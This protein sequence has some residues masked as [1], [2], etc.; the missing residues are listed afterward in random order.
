[1][2]PELSQVISAIVL[3]AG[4]FSGWRFAQ[5]LVGRWFDERKMAAGDDATIRQEQAKRIAELEKWL[6]DIQSEL[7][8]TEVRA[9]QA[10]AR[11]AEL[12]R[13]IKDMEQWCGQRREM[14]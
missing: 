2:S 3:G 9:V 1:M 13:R 10:E 14:P 4:G 11:V 6:Y 7:R 5:Y 12:E 8:K